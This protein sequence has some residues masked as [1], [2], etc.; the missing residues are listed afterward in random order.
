M[1]LGVE[2]KW[3]QEKERKNR[4]AYKQ[5]NDFIQYE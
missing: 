1:W 5:E 3:K 2:N 4:V